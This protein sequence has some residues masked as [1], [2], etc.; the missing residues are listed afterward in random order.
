MEKF[1]ADELAKQSKPGEI[2]TLGWPDRMSAIK[3]D[4][5]VPFR[6]LVKLGEP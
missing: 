1:G 2:G 4:S 6:I 3:S 5:A